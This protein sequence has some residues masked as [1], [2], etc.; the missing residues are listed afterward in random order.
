MQLVRACARSQHACPTLQIVH[1][2]P[3]HTRPSTHAPAHTPQHTRPL[4]MRALFDA[5]HPYV[6]EADARER[7]V[8]LDPDD[9]VAEHVGAPAVAL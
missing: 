8:R 6:V 9:V 3:Q 4:C 5:E 2:T 1:P 7:V